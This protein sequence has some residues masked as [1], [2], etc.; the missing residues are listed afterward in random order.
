MPTILCEI[1]TNPMKYT[2]IIHQKL[3]NSRKQSD[4]ALQ[5]LIIFEFLYRYLSLELQ[6]E[7][8]E[9]FKIEVR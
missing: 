2:S 4:V 3:R 6:M 1:Q 7:Y 9:T 5:V 8:N